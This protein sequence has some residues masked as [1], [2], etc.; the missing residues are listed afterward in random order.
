GCSP[1]ALMTSAHDKRSWAT[2]RQGP[3][4]IA[5]SCKDHLCERI[6]LISRPF[7]ARQNAALDGALGRGGWASRWGR[8]SLGGGVVGGPLPCPLGGARTTW[9][10]SCA[11]R[12]VW[13]CGPATS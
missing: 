7:G 11:S 3:P 2:R 8:A 13:R 10:R 4:R 9:R 1:E 6:A 12:P 5:P